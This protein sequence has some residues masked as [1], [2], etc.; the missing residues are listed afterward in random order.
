MQ[1]QE[2]Y[3]RCFDRAIASISTQHHAAQPMFSVARLLESIPKEFEDI[4]T[5][6]LSKLL[7]WAEVA[8]TQE[9]LEV[10]NLAYRSLWEELLQKFGPAVERALETGGSLDSEISGR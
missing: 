4:E 9:A 2:D 8:K 1:N 7:R 5:F 6:R 10:L 3:Q